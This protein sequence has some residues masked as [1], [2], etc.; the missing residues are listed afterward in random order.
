MR[1]ILSELTRMK[2]AI[3]H[4][5]KT[6]FCGTSLLEKQ[7]RLY[8]EEITAD[9]N[10]SRQVPFLLLLALFQ[11]SNLLVDYFSKAH[12]GYTFYYLSAGVYQLTLSLVYLLI[13]SFLL[14][15]PGASLRNKQMVYRSFWLLFSLGVLY[16]STLDI[17]ERNSLLN[18]FVLMSSLA[19]VP[20]FNFREISLFAGLNLLYLMVLLFF[21]KEKVFLIQQ[22]VMAGVSA[23]TLSQ[24]LYASFFS[25]KVLQKRLKDANTEL[26][27]LSETDR[28]T[29]LLNRLGLENQMPALL[30]KTDRLSLIIFDID[31]FKEY[32]DK[33]GH[34]QGDRC[35]QMVAEN[36]KKVFEKDGHLLCRFGGEEFAIFL[37]G[38]TALEPLILARE[39]KRAVECENFP[40]G[41]VKV[42]DFVTVSAGVVSIH[43]SEL[44][45]I[46]ALIT[47]ADRELYHAK[48]NGRNCI[49]Y[50]KKLYC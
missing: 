15:K 25:S 37:T 6:I 49:S 5:T 23:I 30:E 43:I 21:L 35:L 48:E 38:P 41:C 31:H 42:S 27:K 20:I 29:G 39:L 19:I 7:D 34:L 47:D 9:T 44:D 26:E 8:L 46:E 17:L 40:A 28:L 12:P 11:I 10:I 33:F 2:D 4:A 36:L 13:V 24:M 45:G 14:A 50:G 1:N 22:A 32:N 18:V 3:L 16:L